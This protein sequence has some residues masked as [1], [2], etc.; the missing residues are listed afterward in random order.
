MLL[1]LILEPAQEMLYFRMCHNSDKKRQPETW[2]I[3]NI[4][5]FWLHFFHA[6]E[7]HAQKKI[8]NE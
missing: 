6:A 7:E 8:E 5:F 3:F 1:M 2:M 4:W